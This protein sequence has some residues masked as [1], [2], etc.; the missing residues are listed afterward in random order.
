[1][2]SSRDR[3]GGET[4]AGM[5]ASIVFLSLF[6]PLSDGLCVTLTSFRVLSHSLTHLS[7]SLWFLH[8]PVIP[9]LIVRWTPFLWPLPQSCPFGHSAFWFLLF[10]A[11]ALFAQ[12]SLKQSSSVFIS[13][14][15]YR[16]TCLT[17]DLRTYLLPTAFSSQLPPT[18]ATS[19]TFP[20]NP[21]AYL[22]ISLPPL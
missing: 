11:F 8:L 1:M 7:V 17:I 10:R 6:L 20:S 9:L 18:L 19:S 13:S 12:C 16:L 2:A 15:P 22:L 4:S 14:S 5:F 21:P 3:R